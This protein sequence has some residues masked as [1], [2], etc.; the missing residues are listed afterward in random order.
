MDK[1]L[2]EIYTPK[3]A[4]A[5]FIEHGLSISRF[6]RRVNDGSIRKY[7]PVGKKKRGAVYSKADVDRVC[8]QE[9]TNAVQ[10]TSMEV[11]LKEGRQIFWVAQDEANRILATIGIIPLDEAIIIGFLKEELTLLEISITDVQDFKAGTA[12]ACYMVAAADRER[13]DAGDALA[14]LMEKLLTYWCEQYPHISIHML[15]TLSSLPDMHQSSVMFLLKRFFFSRRRDLSPNPNKAVWELPLVEPNPSPAIQQY[16]QCSEEKKMLVA[17]YQ[18]LEIREQSFDKPP[19]ET[20]LEF[21]LFGAPLEYRQVRTKEEMAALVRMSALTFLAP[22]ATPKASYDE[23]TNAWFS[24]FQQSPE[25]FHIV[26]C[27]GHI[28][29]FISLIPLPMEV[30]DNILR[31]ANPVRTITIDKVKSFEL[32]ESLNIY[33]HNWVVTPEGISSEQ[34]SY[35][36]AKMLREMAR[37]FWGF[38]QRGIEISAL[39]T[40]SSQKD[41]IRISEHLGM[42]HLEIPGVTDKPDE[43][44]G[45]RVFRLITS[46]SQNQLMVRYRQELAAYKSKHREPVSNSQA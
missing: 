9:G 31:G 36:G 7:P 1:T 19:S 22:G 12:H 8:A 33:V 6:H 45:K 16:Q 41:G 46:T 20:S 29:G 28:I 35:A 17:E 40:R 44:G 13:S 38:G 2:E 5:R 34:K 26:A 24:W 25:V 42:E 3:E 15:Y 27:K 18:E 4:T 21:R 32:G 14:Q 30:I 11:W 10:P 37:M 23:I 43:E 39:Y